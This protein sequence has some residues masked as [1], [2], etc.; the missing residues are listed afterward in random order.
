MCVFSPVFFFFFFFFF[1]GFFFFFSLFFFFFFFFFSR[2]FSFSSSPFFDIH[3]VI[4]SCLRCADKSVLGGGNVIL[5][6]MILYRNM[7]F[8]ST[9]K[10]LINWSPVFYRAVAFCL[11]LYASRQW[12]VSW[13]LKQLHQNRSIFGW[14]NILLRSSESCSSPL[15]QNAAAARLESETGRFPGAK[16]KEN[17]TEQENASSKTSRRRVEF[18]IRQ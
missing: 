18:S 5:A 7:F 15:P 13:I 2:R 6:I 1:S 11:N 10:S 17:D 8:F 9:S 3:K 4:E 12:I 14:S 16:K